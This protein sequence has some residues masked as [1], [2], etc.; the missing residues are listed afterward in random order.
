MNGRPN[1]PPSAVELALAC[2]MVTLEEGDPGLCDRWV[3]HAESDALH[4]EI[5]RLH[6]QAPNPELVA[7]LHEAMALARSIRWVV[8]AHVRPDAK[9]EARRKRRER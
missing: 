7:N 2:L 3:Q 9:A 1:D 5:R 8:K 6:T 4:A